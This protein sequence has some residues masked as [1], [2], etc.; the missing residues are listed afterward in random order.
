M[1]LSDGFF[2]LAVELYWPKHIEYPT[3]SDGFFAVHS[4][5]A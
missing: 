3:V 4:F 1:I 5:P 2:L